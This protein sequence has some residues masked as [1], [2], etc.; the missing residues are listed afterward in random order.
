MDCILCGREIEEDE[1]DIC[2]S[3]FRVLKVKYP[4]NK[5]LEEQIK[6]HKRNAKK[7]KKL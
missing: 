4:K 6:C 1:N 5:C 3:C 7:L 2:T